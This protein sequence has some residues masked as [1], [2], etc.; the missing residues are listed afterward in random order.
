MFRRLPVALAIV[1]SA[2]PAAWCQ[3]STQEMKAAQ[4]DPGAFTID[5]SSIKIQD[6]GPTVKPADIPPPTTEP[7]GGN[8]LPVLNEIINTGLKIWKIIADNH[9]VVDVR[10]QYATARLE[11]SILRT[12]A[13]ADQVLARPTNRFRW[14]TVRPS[15][16]IALRE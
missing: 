2:A 14:S 6:L 15:N 7:G 13:S 8:P 12:S 10:T 5:E 9:P 3:F 1:L 16:R 4:K 11:R